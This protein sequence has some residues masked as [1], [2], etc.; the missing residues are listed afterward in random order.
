MSK[1]LGRLSL[2]MAAIIFVSFCVL[3]VHAQENTQPEMKQGKAE[4][5]TASSATTVTGCLQKGQ[6]PGGFYITGDDGK[7]WELTGTKVKL[8]D[9]VGHQVTVTG[10]PTHGSKQKE[11]KVGASE[12]KEAAGNEHADLRVRSLKMV[13]DACN[14]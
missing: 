10:R 12:K 7:I 8:G 3:T 13:S 6:E 4:H 11:Q 9:H 1:A 14:K 5:K 2:G